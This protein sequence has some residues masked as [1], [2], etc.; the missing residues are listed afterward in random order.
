MKALLDSG[1]V[2]TA[3]QVGMGIRQRLIEAGEDASRFE[4][5]LQGMANNPQ[6]ASDFL[7]QAVNAMKP[8]VESL[9]TRSGAKPPEPKILN[10]SQVSPR[11]Q[12]FE[13]SP[14]GVV[15]AKDVP[16]FK[17]EAAPSKR[18]ILQRVLPTGEIQSIQS[19]GEGNFFDLENNPISVRANERL[20]D[21]NS[22][23]GSTEDLGLG[24]NELTQLRDAE[25]AAKTFIA[26]AGDA[27]DLLANT[28]DINTFVAKAA[29]VVNSLQQEA[30][31]I[32]RAFDIEIDESLL[33]PATHSATFD[34]LG[35][36][37]VQMRSL[38]TSLAYQAAAASGQTSRSVSDRDVRRFIDEIGANSADPRAFE[39]SIMD[40]ASRVARGFEINY[41][42]RAR[43]DYEGDLG[44]GSI[45]GKKPLDVKALSDEELF[46]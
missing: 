2:K 37:N 13:M 4:G 20:I 18:S 16:G 1:E 11:G 46:N 14:T 19:D 7:G 10:D 5:I 44:L 30:K 17:A 26:T 21:S 15:T 27:L 43:K 40:V 8:K 32:G 25:V 3:G 35:I 23:S 6:A 39:Q 31:A 22:L 36:K 33:D 12:I 28:P 34:D 45:G 9:L 38:I 29:S 41:S 42:T 24:N